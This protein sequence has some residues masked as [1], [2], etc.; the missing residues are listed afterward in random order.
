MIKIQNHV[1]G[2]D[3][4]I[5]KQATRVQN[6]MRQTVDLDGLAIKIYGKYMKFLQQKVHEIIDR[7]P[8]P[9]V[10]GKPKVNEEDARRKMDQENRDLMA[11]NL[12]GLNSNV[13]DTMNFSEIPIENSKLQKAAGMV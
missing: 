5:K 4:E 8:T 12:V 11:D 6:G 3:K 2:K 1:I 10:G 7:P 13:N 9:L